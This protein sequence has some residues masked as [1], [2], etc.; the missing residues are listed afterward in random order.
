MTLDQGPA[1][2]S[3]ALRGELVRLRK[4][5]G[6]TQEQVA[7]T[8]DWSPSKLIRV[9]GGRSSI[10][11]VDL[12]ALL[13]E[14]GVAADGAERE[15]LQELNRAARERGWWDKYREEISGPYLAYVGYEAGAA[16]IRQFQA[17]VVPG[18]LQTREYAEVLTTSEAKP[19]E[20]GPV[21]GL[22][23]QRQ[24]ELAQRSAPPRQYY[25]LDE[26][27]IRRQVGIKTDSTIMP[28][29]LIYIADRAA[30]DELVTV[31][32]IPFK[33][34]SHA[35]LGAGPFTLLQ[36]EGGLPDFL[37]RDLGR[38]ESVAMT[39]DDSQVSDFADTF[40][41]LVDVALPADE[42]IDFIRNAAEE[43]S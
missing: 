14:Y 24:S 9:E 36:F 43:M 21:V 27:V 10:T 37:Y 20:I 6:L 11:K 13:G 23:M 30:Q 25:V 3:A 41:S 18:L 1:V 12:D 8:L 39:N 38:G 35:G 19:T 7:A 40:E 22:R 5:K 17:T 42:S 34:G 32:V 16:F 29:Q 26:A 28:T 4:V 33:E 15:R 2:Q 31:R